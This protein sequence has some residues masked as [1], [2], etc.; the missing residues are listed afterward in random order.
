MA[1]NT[2]LRISTGTGPLVQCRERK[3]EVDVRDRDQKDFN[4]F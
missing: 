3:R 1:M 4:A 2:K